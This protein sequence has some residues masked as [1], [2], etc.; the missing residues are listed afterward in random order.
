MPIDERNIEYS[1]INPDPIIEGKA[2]VTSRLYADGTE[3]MEITFSKA[4][5]KQNLPVKNN[6]RIP[7]ELRI[8]NKDYEA[9]I[10]MTERNPHIW[11]CPNLEHQGSKVRLADVLKNAGIK[12][13]DSII[14]QVENKLFILLAETQSMD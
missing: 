7:I 11:I 9:G 8:L 5:Y 3:V 10:R 1:P 14:F 13:N 2:R 12:K 6:L 4:K